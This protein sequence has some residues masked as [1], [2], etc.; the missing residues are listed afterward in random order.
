M[1][2][3]I[4]LQFKIVFFAI[5]SG[6]ILGFLFDFYR[7]I[8]GICRNKV[9]IIIEDVLFWIWA[10]IV[11][12]IFLLKFN[13]AFLGMYVYVFMALTLIFYLTCVS[14][15]LRRIQH[16]ILAIILRCVRIVLKNIIYVFKNTFMS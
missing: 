5:A 2:L 16:K 9:L 7:E 15:Y 1:L 6:I 12:F 3:D 11:V 10:S 8:R 13:Y 14:K 4:N